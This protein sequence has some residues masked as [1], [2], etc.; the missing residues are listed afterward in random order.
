MNIE[1]M[2]RIVGESVDGQVS[3]LSDIIEIYGHSNTQELQ[4][5]FLTKPKVVHNVV[6]NM[7]MI[8]SLL[9]FKEDEKE[10]SNAKQY[11]F[12]AV[13]DEPIVRDIVAIY[14]KTVTIDDI[15]PNLTSIQISEKTDRLMMML[16]SY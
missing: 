1:N 4:H 10:L 2:K 16:T 8:Y 11:L 6:L 7:L 9:A 14:L 12:Q 13:Q 15:N 3:I 5:V